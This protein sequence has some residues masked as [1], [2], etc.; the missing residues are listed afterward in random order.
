M[1]KHFGFIIFFT[2]IIFIFLSRLILMKAAFI[3]GDYLDQFYPWSMAYSESIKNLWFPFWCRYFHSGF[4]LMAE[5]Q[6]GGFY[7]FNI[8]MFFLLPFKGAYN[9]MAVFHFI[10]AGVFTYLFTRK[11]GACQWAGALSALCF[12]FGSAYAGCFYNIVTLRTLS[13]FPLVLLLFEYAFKE[14]R[15]LYILIAGIICGMQFLA[16][17]LQMAV[18]A[19]IFYII[20]LL[21]GFSINRIAV[22]ARLKYLFVFAVIAGIISLP[23]VLLTLQLLKQTAR[24]SATL[25]FALWGS[26]APPRILSAFFPYWISMFG[27]QVFIGSVSVFFLIYAFSHAKNT[28]AIRPIM[29][30]GLIALFL[31]FGRYNPLYV[32]F[33][34]LSGF[35]GMRNPSKFLFFTLFAC[36]VLAGFGFDKFF[37]NPDKK[38]SRLCAK[39]FLGVSFTALSAYVFTNVFL[40]MRKEWFLRF[41][42][43]YINTNV[44]GKAHHRYTQEE[45][46]SRIPGIYEAVIKNIGINI[47]TIVSIIM[48]IACVLFGIYILKTFK[49]SAK[50]QKPLWLK[51]A[52]FG[53]IF[54]D[55][56]AYS[57]YGTGFRGN[58]RA[59]D[60]VSPSHNKILD[61][62]KKDDSLFRI[63]PFGVRNGKV[64]FWARPNANIIVGLDSIAGYTPLAK[65]TYRQAL[66]PLEIVD[67]SLGVLVPDDK[68]VSEC[69]YQLKLLNVKYIV[70]ERDLNFSFVEKAAF[71]EGVY[72]YRLKDAFP[73]VFFTDNINNTI[74][75]LK[76]DYLDVIEYKDGF[77]R[78][79]LSVKTDGFVVF[80]ENYDPYW[81]AFVDDKE[82]DIMEAAGLIQAVRITKGTHSVTFKYTPQLS[83]S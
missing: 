24:D 51:T 10:I 4:P 78:I 54:I 16:G 21:Y 81:Q 37:N 25:G 41:L 15:L 80:S 52:V 29:A 18:Y 70:T 64:P 69:L 46:F 13:W 39:I 22:R 40:R 1:K 62:L 38:K 12:C 42:H 33:L 20:Y 9:L 3:G 48:L 55:I 6:I 45:Y 11:I 58:I 60:Y 14:K 77:V 73:R 67:D 76:P 27:Q 8:I 71:D 83:R 34:K 66:K 75:P 17:F 7:P 68:A 31:S 47:F 72:L 44:I 50:P 61:I 57:F 56:F 32:L 26:F 5:G 82:T 2:A 63:L 28:P 30:I 19:F 43:D 74:R 59:F 36:S 65:K 35:C 49:S 23:Q 53:I 79:S